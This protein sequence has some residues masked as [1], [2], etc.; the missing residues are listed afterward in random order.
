LDNGCEKGILWLVL[1]I[2]V[3]GPL[4]FGAVRPQEFLVI[5]ALTVGI[6]LLWAA[7][8]W[9]D[10]RP[11]L[12]WP[13][14]CW[15][16]AAFAAY[17]LGRYLTS[18]I[19]YV[20]RQELIRV[21]IYAFLFLAILNNLH[22]QE[23]TQVIVFTLLLVAMALSGYAI[24]QFVT[25]S[26][27]VL[28]YFKPYARRGS[29]T[30]I[31]PNHLAG[32]LEMILPLGLAWVLVSRAKPVAKVFIGYAS[33]VI[34]A[35]IVTTL[36]RGAW[37]S[38]MVVLVVFFA[39]LLLNR[40]YWL[41]SAVLLLILVGLGVFFIPRTP[42]VKDRFQEMT[43]EKSLP[44]DLRGEVWFSTV[45]M[46]RDNFGW[47]VGPGHF[48]HRFGAY[49]TELVQNDPERAHNDYLNTL[50][51]WGVAG[52]AVVLSAL[53]LLG[54]GVFKTW[55]YVRGSPD[56]LGSK[57]SNKLALL[58]G[59][60]L[61]LFAILIHSVVDFNLHIPANAIVAMTLMAMVSSCLR[62]ATEQHWFGAR[63]GIKAALTVLLASG[64]VYL[65]AQSARSARE[66]FYLARA[67]AAQNY[68]SEQIAALEKAAAAEPNNFE[69]AYDLGEVFRVLS[70]EGGGDYAEQ[71]DKAI[72]WYRRSL[73][74]NPHHSYSWLKYG[75]CL[76]WLDR[77]ADARSCFNRALLLEPNGYYA[78]ALM[79]WHYAQV[80]DFAAARSWSERSHR[81]NW[82]SN[83]IADTY[84]EISI[85]KLLENATNTTVLRPPRIP[86]AE[87]AAGTTPDALPAGP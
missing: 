11:K 87:P 47:G 56:D 45:N 4:G 16:A 67:Q 2:L 29:A 23:S 75:M 36:S 64:A 42:A 43:A 24:Y 58:F 82:R 60:A 65:A 78:A 13:P 10:P 3:F 7:R 48:G 25:G 37:I 55:R 50:A 15:S 38:C 84:L 85:Q 44:V 32:L 61:G 14:I 57:K 28:M 31:S 21:L 66:R 70:M 19:E 35:G 86:A 9:L 12:F 39:V 26:D 49:R 68:S 73:Q 83:R 77:P 72:T 71:A 8:L 40:I 17:A 59:G 1:A 76:D 62:F 53:G 41:P 46:W 5:Q 63:L 52:A 27:R 80:E 54:A 69:T 34:L 33:L 79:G 22:R 81:L 51:D 20:A 6:L 74:L 30:Y 18:D